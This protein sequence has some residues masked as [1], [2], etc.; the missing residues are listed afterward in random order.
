M[1]GTSMATPHVAG[2]AA[3]V[4]SCNPG[5]TGAQVADILRQTARPLRDNP[6]DP[7]P[8]DNYGFG[9]V[10]AQA[11]V[12]RACPR[13]TQTIACRQTGPIVCRRTLP[14]TCR[15]STLVRCPSINVLCPTTPIICRETT[16][17]ACRPSAVIPCQSAPIS[18]APSATI[19]CP[20]G[21]VCGMPGQ[22]IENPFGM[23][24]R[25]MGGWDDS[26]GAAGE[27]EGW[28]D[29][30]PYAGHYCSKCGGS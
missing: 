21:P 18:C 14:I 8:N 3:L 23:E 20:S 11:A 22:P 30:D 28:D 12:N 7:V 10:D 19:R 27:F 5:L 17:I 1:S 6:A 9:C 15:P 4:L 29:Y 2:V 16:P 13:I 24:Q 25:N 26:Y